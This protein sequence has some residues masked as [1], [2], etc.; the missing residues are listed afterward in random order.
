MKY[1]DLTNEE[2]KLIKAFENGEFVSVD[3]LASKKKSYQGY[4][5][6][7]LSKKANIN[8]RLSRKVIQ[9]LKAKA[10]ENGI[11]YQTLASSVLHRFAVN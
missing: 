10:V 4:A 9:K 7:T 1:Y 6:D 11:P 8:L 2:K 3:K 5:K